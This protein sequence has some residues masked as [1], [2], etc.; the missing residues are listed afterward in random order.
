M[1]LVKQ[2]YIKRWYCIYIDRKC[3]VIT[4]YDFE[5]NV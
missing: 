3:I 1:L 2:K 4:Y 5:T